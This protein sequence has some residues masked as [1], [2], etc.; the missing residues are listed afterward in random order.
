MALPQS[1]RLAVKIGSYRRNHLWGFRVRAK[2]DNSRQA[3]RKRWCPSQLIA[4]NPASVSKPCALGADQARDAVS[5][6][7]QVTKTKADAVYSDT[8]IS[9]SL[10]PS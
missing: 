7:L 9:H 8:M 5:V 2:V 4:R 3:D 6:N 10:R 1:G